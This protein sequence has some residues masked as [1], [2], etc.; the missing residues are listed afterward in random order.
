M[1]GKATGR[2]ALCERCETALR[3]TYWIDEGEERRTD[4]CGLCTTEGL[5]RSCGLTP[6]I[7]H[8]F[9]RRRGGGERARAGR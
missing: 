8:A 9:R 3:A 5:V 4:R 1:E 7:N 6:R 2:M